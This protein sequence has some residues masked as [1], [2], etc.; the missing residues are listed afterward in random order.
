MRSPW[1]TIALL[2]GAFV[3][4][5]GGYF[6]A[7]AISGPPA[8][9]GEQGPNGPAGAD[10][11]DGAD[12]RDGLDGR[13]GVDGATG[14]RG[15]TGPIGATGP[16]G[17]QGPAGVPGTNG[18]DGADGA[19]GAT[20]PQG[21]AG[22]D[23]ADGATGPAGPPGADGPHSYAVVVD[24]PPSVANGSVT[25]AQLAIPEG[26]WI[27]SAGWYAMTN[28]N[29]NQVCHLVDGQNAFLYEM[30]N[31]SP[32]VHSHSIT[33]VYTTPAGGG[34]MRIVCFAASGNTVTFGQVSISAIEVTH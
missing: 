34:S 8:L 30:I 21:P 4:A 5:F 14:P 16:A 26:T 7:D 32:A 12:G 15:F 13:D 27:V 11:A 25:V 31:M 17:P 23:G 2:V 28:V 22:A 19:D 33:Q 20:G 6:A 9:V 24:N 3:F 18:A 29:D 1:S 10:G